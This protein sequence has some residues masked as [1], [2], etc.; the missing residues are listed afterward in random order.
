MVRYG[1]SPLNAIRSATNVAAELL[2]MPGQI[3]T[4][5]AGSDA[6]IIAVRGNPLEN[7]DDIR[8]V[9]FVMADGRIFRNDVTAQTYPWEGVR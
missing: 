7:I 8:H 6:D 2:R 9:R 1:M 5:A 3:G 4:F